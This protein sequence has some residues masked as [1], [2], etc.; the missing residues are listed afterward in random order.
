LSTANTN[1]AERPSI[2]RVTE[3]RGVGKRTAEVIGEA[4]QGVALR[5]AVESAR[6]QQP[7][8]ADHVANVRQ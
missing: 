3:E 8:F 5:Q 6:W 7:P 4:Q 1:R 2:A